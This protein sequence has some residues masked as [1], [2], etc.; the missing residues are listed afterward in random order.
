MKYFFTLAGIIIAAYTAFA[1]NISDIKL[2]VDVYNSYNTIRDAYNTMRVVDS[3]V[4]V[5]DQGKNPTVTFQTDWITLTNKFKDASNKLQNAKLVTDFDAKPYSLSLEDLSNC[6]LRDQNFK[7]LY[8]YNQEFSDAIKR[9][10]D[11]SLFIKKYKDNL[12]KTSQILDFLSQASVRLSNLPIYSSI[13]PLVWHDIEMVVKP[14]LE[15]LKSA[16]EG[17]E[18]KLN[19]EMEKIKDKNLNLTA[20]TDNLNKLLCQIEGAYQD[21]EI[22][23][24]WITK[25]NI[26]KNGNQY[27]GTFTATLYGINSVNLPKVDMIN[28]QFISFSLNIRGSTLSFSGEL[29]KDFKEIRNF[30]EQKDDMSESMVLTK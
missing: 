12:D 29:S 17:H 7:K 10:Q 22:G 2:S 19:S 24:R 23:I 18:K 1:Q 26:M 21:T 27:S 14:A 13:F 20:N 4:K 15:G 8:G 25:L 28:N 16:I 6:Y 9:G 11:E 3:I 30:K 5:I